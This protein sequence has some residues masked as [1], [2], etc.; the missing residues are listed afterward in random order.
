MTQD[1]VR[2]AVTKDVWSEDF[3]KFFY[4]YILQSPDVKMVKQGISA[5]KDPKFDLCVDIY[6]RLLKYCKCKI[7]Y[8]SLYRSQVGKI[9]LVIVKP[10]D[11]C[12]WDDQYIEQIS[13]DLKVCPLV[14]SVESV[15]EEDFAKQNPRLYTCIRWEF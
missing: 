11:I 9:K 10:D 13:W 15:Y 6:K 8:D 7:Y 2:A 12:V 5:L 14:I 1:E 4:T 3:D